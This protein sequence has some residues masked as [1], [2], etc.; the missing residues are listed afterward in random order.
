MQ[1]HNLGLPQPPP[2][3]FKQFSSLSLLSSWDYS[4][5]PSCPANFSILVDTGFHHVGQEG[6]ELLISGDPPSS[7]ILSFK[8][9]I[10]M[11]SIGMLYIFFSLYTKPS[12]SGILYLQHISIQTNHISFLWSFTLVAQAGVQWRNLGS[13]QP[14]PPWLSDSPAS[15]SRVA[16]ITGM[17]HHALLILYF[18]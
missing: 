14:P 17:C 15:A 12:K 18:Q 16:G 6:L 1:W 11:K 7:K 8:H 9:A 2:H 4:H 3:G 13:L 5:P 10:N